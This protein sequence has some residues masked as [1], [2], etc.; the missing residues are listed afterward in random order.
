M[1]LVVTSTRSRVL[2]RLVVTVVAMIALELTA[3]LTHLVA[4]FQYIHILITKRTSEPARSFGNTLSR[5]GYHLMRYN[6]LNENPRPFPFAELP[7]DAEASEA[8]DF[9]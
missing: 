7:K 8:P 9:E 6:T 5:Y 3:V 4:L 2:T 1:N